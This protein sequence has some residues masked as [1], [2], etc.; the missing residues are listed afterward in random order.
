MKRVLTAVLALVMLLSLAA[1]GNT[2]TPS[3]NEP[4]NGENAAPAPEAPE[5]S[6]PA[7]YYNTYMSADPTSMDI[8]R[9]SDSYSSGVVNNVMESLVR[10]G[11]KDGNYVIIP[12]D[13]QTWESNAEGTVWTFHLGNNTWSDGQPVTAHD[14]VYSLR[15]SANPETGCPNEYFLLPVAGYNEVRDG[16]ALETLGV[17][18]LDDKTL[19]VTLSYPVPSFLEMCCGTVY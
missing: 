14:Y 9:I 2:S 18:A 15:R 4:A 19:E 1:C 13:A 12:G 6:A 5:A 3:T 17:K 7:Q 10:M 11:E 16:A 8:S